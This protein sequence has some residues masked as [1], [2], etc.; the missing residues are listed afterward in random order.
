MLV[1]LVL[2]VLVLERWPHPKPANDISL[3]QEREESLGSWADDSIG[4][5][6]LGMPEENY[7]IMRVPIPVVSREV[8]ARFQFSD[9]EDY[10]VVAEAEDDRDGILDQA[11]DRY[12][13]GKKRS[14]R[15]P[16]VV[17]TLPETRS[18]TNS[19]LQVNG[20]TP[21]ASTEGAVDAQFC[22]TTPCRLLVLL[23]IAER[24]PKMQE[25]LL[26]VLALAKV[27]NRTVVLPNV[28]KGRVGTCQ[29]WDFDTYF[30]IASAVRTNGGRAMLMDDFRTW[31][32]ARPRSPTMHSVVVDD[33]PKHN[34]S[35][36]VEHS[37]A[38][39]E[40]AR[41]N[42]RCFGTRFR[43]LN[44]DDASATTVHLVPSLVFQES[45]DEA[46]MLANILSG[47]EPIGVSSQAGPP[48]EGL[49]GECS[50]IEADQAV[51]FERRNV[52]DA[53]ILLLHWDVHRQVFPTP[54]D[55]SIDYSPRI[56]ALADK[57]TR[58]IQPYLAV[59]WHVD[60]VPAAVL[61]AC[62]DALIDMLDILLH[63]H[64]VAQD[65]RTVYFSSDYPLLEHATSD[66]DGVP[67]DDKRMTYQHREAGR[68]LHTAF[69]VGGDLW[70]WRLEAREGLLSNSSPSGLP[71]TIGEDH[72]PGDDIG[73]QETLAKV[74]S[75]NAALF[76]SNTKGCGRMRYV[77]K[78]PTA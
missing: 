11:D 41:K 78:E 14:G 13:F 57:A 68:I 55:A 50:T 3:L 28:G 75:M 12:S 65:I 36:T 71:S 29:R 72:L 31:V 22:A 43:S 76:I 8:L 48:P 18:S 7:H 20:T 44:L 58:E 53:D 32:D 6:L 49:H 21:T 33:G 9:L 46:L 74:I 42:T 66:P 62:A 2:C 16:P 30:D 59:H 10:T 35:A 51:R 60:K 64:S 70:H 38:M 19:R 63:D 40:I 25:Q 52:S 61:P 27:L 4:Y 15:W 26:Q 77:C 73:V 56:W 24:E 37:S 39:Q 69:E 54:P 1:S 45:L 47:N 67:K 5:A 34:G 23:T 17:T